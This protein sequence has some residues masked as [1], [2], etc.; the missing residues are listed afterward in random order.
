MSGDEKNLCVF[1]V[2]ATVVV[3]NLIWATMYYNL[4]V[5]KSYIEAGYIYQPQVHAGWTKPEKQ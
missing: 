3:V 2:G 4:S 5:E 1:L